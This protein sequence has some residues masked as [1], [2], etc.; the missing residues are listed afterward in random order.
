M[1]VLKPPSLTIKK[2]CSL[3]AFT[4]LRLPQWFDILDAMKFQNRIQAGE[5]LG[6]E[7]LSYRIDN[8]FVLAIPRGGVPVGSAVAR[9]L[10]CPLD[11]IPLL[12]I[13]VPWSPEASY[14]AVSVDGTTALN[15]PL[16]HRLEISAR[17]LALSADAVMQEVKRREQLYRNGRSFPDLG[18]KAAILIDDGLG[19][20]YSM[21]AAVNFV[22]KKRPRS[23]IVAAP[24]ASDNAFKMLSAEAGVDRVIVLA[25]DF[26]PL[27]SLSSFYKEFAP[28]TDD[29]VVRY[30]SG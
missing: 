22:K 12:K 9:V 27:F 6:H 10:A 30:L 25:R 26:E 11:V 17:E 16:V 4:A 3:T 8:P 7:L 29:E 20:G 1:T 13:P 21:L 5:K 15:Q 2:I 18:D 14:G 23:I 28:V 19:S 24:V